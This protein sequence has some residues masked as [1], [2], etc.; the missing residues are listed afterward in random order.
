MGG[1]TC[2]GR[3]DVREH[4]EGVGKARV[5]SARGVQQDREPRDASGA[6]SRRG[7]RRRRFDEPEVMSQGGGAMDNEKHV[8]AEGQPG[9]INNAYS[10]PN[11][12]W[13]KFKE[14]A[15]G[16]EFAGPAAGDGA[17]ANESKA[18]KHRTARE[19]RDRATGS[20]NTH[21]PPFGGTEC[22]STTASASVA[23]AVRGAGTTKSTTKVPL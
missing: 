17:A 20:S 2:G 10:G 9:E 18:R 13:R 1:G 15:S 7:G 4:R 5:D 12:A 21:E 3:E 19:W 6:V 14:P 22:E 8:Q 23:V 16:E 11:G